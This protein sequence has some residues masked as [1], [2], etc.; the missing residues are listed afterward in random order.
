MAVMGR[1]EC[2]GAGTSDTHSEGACIESKVQGKG[3]RGK[4]AQ[5]GTTSRV[6][7]IKARANEQEQGHRVH[8]SQS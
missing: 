1:I 5:A 7:R 3:G 2:R 4:A 6:V 8:G